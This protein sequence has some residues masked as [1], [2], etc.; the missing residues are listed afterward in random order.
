VGL[1]ASVDRI[2]IGAFARPN[3]QE[4]PAGE[5]LTGTATADRRLDAHWQLQDDLLDMPGI[6]LDFIGEVESFSE[7]FAR[8]LA[9]VGARRRPLGNHF[10]SSAHEPWPQYYS[11]ALAENVYRAYERDFDRLRYPRAISRSRTGGNA[12]PGPDRSP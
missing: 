4:R 7:D 12:S 10:N 5:S 9:H 1:G 6:K 11:S 2:S 3:W 8:V